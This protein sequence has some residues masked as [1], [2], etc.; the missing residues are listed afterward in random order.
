MIKIILI[1]IFSLLTGVFSSYIDVSQ[2]KAL[3]TQTELAYPSMKIELVSSS[4]GAGCNLVAEGGGC[5]NFP[6]NCGGGGYGLVGLCL[7]R[8]DS[9]H[10][11]ECK[12]PTDPGVASL[13]RFYCNGLLALAN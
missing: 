9:G 11:F 1:A 3:P 7:V 10:S 12:L 6:T 2:N 13:N 5:Q 4:G 8:C